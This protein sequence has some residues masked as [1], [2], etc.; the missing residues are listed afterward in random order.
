MGILPFDRVSSARDSSEMGHS[1]RFF[2]P[3]D[4]SAIRL[5]SDSEHGFLDFGDGI[6]ANLLEFDMRRVGHLVRR[7]VALLRETLNV[8]P[9]TGA[10]ASARL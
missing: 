9:G 1:C 6:I 5:I 8:R 3:Y 7:D 4:M 2:H 10:T